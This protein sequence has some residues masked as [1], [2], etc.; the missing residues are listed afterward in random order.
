MTVNDQTNTVAQA[1]ALMT[2][3]HLLLDAAGITLAAAHLEHAL[4]VLN[5]EFPVR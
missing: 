5:I 1:S 2:E 4:H 3:A